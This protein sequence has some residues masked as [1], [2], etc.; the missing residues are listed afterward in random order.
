MPRVP[1]KGSTR[2][3]TARGT[4]RACCVPE[5]FNSHAGGRSVVLA[6]LSK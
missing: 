1:E 4:T 6:D 3:A 2:A 5:I